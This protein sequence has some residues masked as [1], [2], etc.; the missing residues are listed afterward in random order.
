MSG[1]ARFPNAPPHPPRDCH[2]P[3]TPRGGVPTGHV[4][5]GR[6]RRTRRNKSILRIADSKHRANASKCGHEG[7]E[8]H[9]K[10][11]KRPNRTA[12]CRIMNRRISKSIRS[13]RG[14]HDSD[15]I[16]RQSA[17]CGD[18]LARNLDAFALP[19]ECG[20]LTP[21]FTFEQRA[22]LTGQGLAGHRRCPSSLS[23]LGAEPAQCPV[24]TSC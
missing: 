17:V 22:N 2:P 11:S 1:R 20:G 5:V 21:L 10:D 23:D 18:T 7:A 24:P 13:F 9:A 12:D 4:L 19:L 14:L 3:W 15:L 8:G 6:G 16:I